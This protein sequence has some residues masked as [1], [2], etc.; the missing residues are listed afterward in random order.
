L[1]GDEPAF[2]RPHRQAEKF[3]PE[4]GKGLGIGGINGYRRDPPD[5]A[6]SDRP[7]I[8]HGVWIRHGRCLP[9]AGVLIRTPHSNVTGAHA[10]AR[11]L[12]CGGGD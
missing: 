12:Y 8:G 4:P 5:T 1:Q 11:T 9:A 6:W 7:I 2:P 3:G 10:S